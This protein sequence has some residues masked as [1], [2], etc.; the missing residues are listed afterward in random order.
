LQD[1]KIVLLLLAMMVAITANLIGLFEIGT[2]SGGDS[3]TRLGGIWGSFW[4]GVLAAVVATPCTGPFMAAAIGAA[5]LLPWFAALSVFAG[6]GLGIALPFLAIAY[7]PLIRNRMPRP[8][9]W[10][11]TLRRLMAVPMGLTALALGWLLLRLTGNQGLWIGI[12]MAAL[13][14][15]G[16][17]VLGRVKRIGLSPLVTALIIAGAV[18]VAMPLLPNLNSGQLSSRDFLDAQPFSAE[19]LSKLRASGTPVFVYFTADWCVTCKVNEAAAIDRAQ[20]RDA[21]AKRSIKVL[22]GDL[23]RPDAAITRFLASQGRSGVPLYLF[24]PRSG[25]PEILPQVLTVDI[26][27]RLGE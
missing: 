25:D 21:F 14:I 23:T 13:L 7:V 2:I 9:P 20:T 17:T 22:K 3:L 15:L 24:Y 11:V 1:P 10:M 6:L 12:A 4:T 27:S 26:L 19:Q 16:L 18:A 8:G 5:L